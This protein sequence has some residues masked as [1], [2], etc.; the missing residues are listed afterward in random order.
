MYT[1]QAIFTAPL[2]GLQATAS[3]HPGRNTLLASRPPPG[4]DTLGAV[5]SG[6]Q[7]RSI[8]VAPTP[9]PGATRLQH[10]HESRSQQRISLRLRHRWA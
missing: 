6:L 2:G 10:L 3:E 9:V 5:A 7:P 1:F 4:C 8:R